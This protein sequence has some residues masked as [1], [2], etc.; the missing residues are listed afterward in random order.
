MTSPARHYLSLQTTEALWRTYMASRDFLVQDP[1]AR[2]QLAPIV[3]HLCRVIYGSDTPPPNTIFDLIDLPTFNFYEF[4]DK[5]AALQVDRL[6]V[7]LD[8]DEK[9]AQICADIAQKDPQFYGFGADLPVAPADHWCPGA[10]P[11]H[12]FADRAAAERIIGAQ[13]LRDA[14]LTGNGV[15]V[16]LIDQAIDPSQV[17]KYGGRLPLGDTT[18]PADIQTAHSTMI[19][20]SIQSLAPDATIFDCPILP[21]RLGELR[22]FLSAV[23]TAYDDIGANI[24][25]FRHT[26]EHPGPWV[27]VNAWAVYD[28]STESQ[29]VNYTANINHQFNRLVT[30]MANRKVDLVFAAGNCGQFGP[31]IRCGARD[32]GPGN[33]ILGANGH[34]RVLSVGAVRADGLWLGY[35]SQGP[36]LI[37]REKPDIC[38]PSEFR[39]TDDAHFISTGSSAACGIAAGA[40]AAFR[41]GWS[42]KVIDPDALLGLVRKSAFDP[43]PG[44]EGRLGNGILNVPRL[45]EAAAAFP[46]DGQPAA[47]V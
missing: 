38:A 10:R 6:I 8:L 29:I 45:L 22:K 42:E 39:E 20:R 19:L 9:A 27:I 12:V 13:A 28:R 24:D 5:L 21:P 17:K 15:N 31:D 36:G 26:V 1:S 11:D 47:D 18:L 25:R 30:D 37:E 14:K 16:V 2:D 23:Q 40:I 46:R 35:S 34:P 44:W 41:S 3:Q 4:S 33:S 7:A 32:R 43:E